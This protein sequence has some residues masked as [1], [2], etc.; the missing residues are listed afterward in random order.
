MSKNNG[1]T[2]LTMAKRA[3]LYL[4]HYAGESKSK[5][6]EELGCNRSRIYRELK[7]NSCCTNDSKRKYFPNLA[8]QKALKRRKRVLKLQAHSDLKTYVIA[9]LKIGW[10]PEMIAGRLKREHGVTIISHEC[11]YAYIY[12]ERT[13]DQ[14]LYLHLRKKRSWR[15]PKILRN[16]HGP[17]PNRIA[18]T[19]RPQIISTRQT[20]GHWEGDLVLFNKTKTNLI[21]LRERK[22]RFMLAIKNASKQAKTTAD[23]IIERFK[24]NR[25]SLL[26]TVTLDNGGEFADHERI[27]E[28]LN[29]DIFFCKPYASYEKG[30]VENGNRELRYSLPRDIL[31]DGYNQTDI[32]KIINNINHRPLKCLDYQTPVEVMLKKY[33]DV[34]KQFVAVRG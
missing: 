34:L 1:F 18:I 17:I 12:D 24:G 21:T 2:H 19:E 8:H 16:H 11:I 9:K 25:K 30:T 29:I 23:N 33:G 4:L 22:S 6:A 27:S 32:D 7:R 31:I 10:S 26:A 28:A 20:F 5:I 15:K 14:R 3:N 13:R